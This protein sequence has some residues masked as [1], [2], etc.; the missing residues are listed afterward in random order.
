VN[1]QKSILASVAVAPLEWISSLLLFTMMVVTFIDVIGRYVFSAPIFGAA[2]MVQFL[3]AGTVFSAMGLVSA[4][5]GHIFVELLAPMIE[6]RI[7]KIQRAVV[8]FFSIAGLLVIG[9]QLMRIGVEALQT[10]KT[11]IVLEWPI[12]LV[13]LPCAFFCALAAL[14]QFTSAGRSAS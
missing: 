1:K 7:P 12:A 13:A 11:T 5:D 3:L 6:A 9:F 4:R 8:S 10:D 14:L 2:E